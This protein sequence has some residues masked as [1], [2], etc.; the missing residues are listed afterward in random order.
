MKCKYKSKHLD[1]GFDALDR[2]NIRFFKAPNGLKHITKLNECHDSSQYIL[3]LET[4][5]MPL[6]I[7]STYLYSSDTV[8]TNDGVFAQVQC[9]LPPQVQLSPNLLPVLQVPSNTSTLQQDLTVSNTGT[10]CR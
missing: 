3:F 9:N 2:L 4:L 6:E 5:Q 7:Y 1:H 10:A 8:H